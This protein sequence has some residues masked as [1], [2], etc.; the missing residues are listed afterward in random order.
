MLKKSRKQPKILASKKKAFVQF[1]CAR[2]MMSFSSRT[3]LKHHSLKH[4]EAL[5]D[6][7]LLREGHIPDTNKI[8]SEFRGKNKIIIT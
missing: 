4:T 7:E 1:R 6:L 3:K 2:C 8:G 5:K